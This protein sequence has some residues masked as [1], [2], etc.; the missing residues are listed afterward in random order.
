M[1]L[2]SAISTVAVAAAVTWLCAPAVGGL[3]SVG[4]VGL[5][6]QVFDGQ[7]ATFTVATGK[8]ARVRCTL[9][10]RF[11]G[12]RVSRIAHSDTTGHASWRI[13]IPAVPPG[14]ATL[15]ATCAGAGSATGQVVVQ[16]P[17][18][19]P[20][21]TVTRQGF[22]EVFPQ[23]Q[24][25]PSGSVSYGLAIHNERVRFDATNVD[26]LVNFVD[27]SNRVLGTDHVAIAR[28]PAGATVYHGAR[29][30][31]PYASTDPVTRLET[32]LVSATS[33]QKVP[34]TPLLVSDMQAA[35]SVVVPGGIDSIRGQILNPS[36]LQMERADVG[37]LILDPSGKVIGGGSAFAQGPL[38]RGSREFFSSC[39]SYSDIQLSDEGSILVS[40]VPTYQTSTP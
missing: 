1:K 9:T 4:F 19:T 3:S 35:P 7:T 5:P 2:R 32:V 6:S 26:F 23:N 36:K 8:P 12:A 25:T 27:A 13:R 18:Q 15:S 21:L 40:A 20:K 16:Q 33:A 39:C 24:L 34:S 37:V 38:S 29:V 14:P 31:V 22:T 30:S 17:L 11:R 10:I 28:I